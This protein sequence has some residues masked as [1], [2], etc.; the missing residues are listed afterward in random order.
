MSLRRYT[1][2]VGW[3]LLV[4]TLGQMIGTGC[5]G[6]YP[7][8]FLLK[9]QLNVDP[10]QMAGFFFWAGLPWSF[11]PI[12]GLLSDGLPIR[13]TR[14]RYYLI[15]SSL[16]GGTLWLAMYAV[17]RAYL[18]LLLT[19]LALNAMLV[20]A[21]VATGGLLVEGGQAHGATGRLSALRLIVINVCTVVGAPL[22]GF[23][24][25]RW[26]GLT[27]ITGGLLFFSLIPVTLL[28]LRERPVAA[29]DRPLRGV[30]EQLRRVFRH[31]DLWICGG[32]FF[33]VQVAPGTGTPLLY[34]Q[35]DTLKFT[36]QFIG[37]L[38]MIY[39]ATGLVASLVYPLLCR[40]VR[41]RWLIALAIA[42]TVASNLAYLG[43]VS[44][45]TAMVI[46][47]AAGLGIT[48]A[49]LPLFDLAARAASKGSEALA[50]SLMIA[51]WNVGLSLS[52]V[53][54]SA[55]YGRYHLTFRD[56][57]WVNAGSTALILLVVPFLPARLVDRREGEAGARQESRIPGG[58]QP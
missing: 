33:L 20:L 45:T 55:L 24:A 10:I 40:R 43:Y 49:Q 46:E 29:P 26:F 36:P 35:T 28:F 54:G 8:R 17:P 7:L 13:G 39:G 4:T 42:F 18:P 1:A 31:R 11:K 25:G 27:A 5:I 12:A 34:Y 52:D 32:L 2:L 30:W 47:G 37:N 14:R 16:I 44:K 41:L 48:L 58:V 57:V 19:A 38:G 22:G 23:L 21:S 6:Y 56:L 9:D 15:L 51:L 3:G 50:Y 53:I